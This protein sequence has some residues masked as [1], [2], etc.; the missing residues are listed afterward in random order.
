MLVQMLEGE[1]KKDSVMTK[2][3]NYDLT[4]DMLAFMDE[5][6]EQGDYENR[7]HVLKRAVSLMMVEWGKKSPYEDQY[8]KEFFE[9]TVEIGDK[10]PGVPFREAMAQLDQKHF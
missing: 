8:I 5:V 3:R 6:V 7:Q 2:K 9:L 1:F 4:P 10:D